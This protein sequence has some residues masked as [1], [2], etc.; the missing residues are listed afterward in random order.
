MRGSSTRKPRSRRR[1]LSPGRRRAA[2]RP[3]PLTWPRDSAGSVSNTAAR[4]VYRDLRSLTAR[5]STAEEARVPHRLFGHVDAAESY[6]VGRWLR[7]VA[8]VLEEAARCGALPIVVGG[9][10]L[11]LKALTG[12]LVA[13]PPIPLPTREALR[14][15]LARQ[16]A[17]ALHAELTQRD[18]AAAAR[19]PPGDGVRIV[20]ALEVIEATGQPLAVWA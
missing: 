3:L 15:R 4:Q 13:I 7:D 2:S 9:T 8:L 1:C 18:P 14:A 5:P 16:G 12:G 19:L 20:R 11:Y 10:G 17:G 6:S